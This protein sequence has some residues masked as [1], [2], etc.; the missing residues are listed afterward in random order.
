MRSSLRRVSAVALVLGLATIGVGLGP[1]AAHADDPTWAQVQ[2]AKKNVRNKASEVAVIQKALDGLEQEAAR[3]G[4]IA[5]Q[6]AAA[7]TA[8]EN[9][10]EAAQQVYDRLHQQTT[11]AAGK[12][13]AARR[14]AAT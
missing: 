14:T 8:A 9:R 10:L 4:T 6:Q 2:A 1:T 11:A 13:R 3:L 5:L 7:A 12:A